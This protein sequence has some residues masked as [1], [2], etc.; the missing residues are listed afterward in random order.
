ML[1]IKWTN[2]MRNAR[3]RKREEGKTR[4][5]EKMVESGEKEN[6][7]QSLILLLISRKLEAQLSQDLIGDP[8]CQLREP[9]MAAKKSINIHT[10]EQK[11]VNSLVKLGVN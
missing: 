4:E 9:S 2:D 10:K 5:E 3:D 11:G 6:Y 7:G 1:D 8:F